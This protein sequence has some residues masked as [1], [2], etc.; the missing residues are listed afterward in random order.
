MVG[1]ILCVVQAAILLGL[2]RPVDAAGSASFQFWGKRRE[3]FGI[4][5]VAESSTSAGTALSRT[6]PWAPK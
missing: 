1:A 3:A 4:L 6:L 5:F 2:S